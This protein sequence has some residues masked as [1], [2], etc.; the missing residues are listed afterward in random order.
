MVH[1]MYSNAHHGCAAYLIRHH[2]TVDTAGAV[3]RHACI[4][5]ENRKRQHT[6]INYDHHPEYAEFVLVVDQAL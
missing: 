6:I 5:Q 1:R 3:L 2:L 4:K